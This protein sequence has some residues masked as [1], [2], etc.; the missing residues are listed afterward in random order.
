METI[1]QE[2]VA[3]RVT[4]SKCN[5]EF[6]AVRKDRS[7]IPSSLEVTL[8]AM[9]TSPGSISTNSPL[10]IFLYG[11]RVAISISHKKSDAVFGLDMTPF[12]NI[13]LQTLT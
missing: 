10:T 7:V 12:S 11:F 9:M 2:C 5:S 1:V 4:I 13:F 6:S 8:V 3:L